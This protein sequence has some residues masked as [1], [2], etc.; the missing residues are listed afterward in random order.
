MFCAFS[1]CSNASTYFRI[2]QKNEREAQGTTEKN[3]KGVSESSAMI[4][5]L[6][7]IELQ[8]ETSKASAF[9]T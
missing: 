8:R 6:T 3:F 4:T 5:N 1:C 9:H 7:R 2:R